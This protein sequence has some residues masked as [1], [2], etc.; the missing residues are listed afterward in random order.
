MKGSVGIRASQELEFF[1]PS[2]IFEESGV[3]NRI[4]MGMPGG[5]IGGF[6]EMGVMVGGV[7]GVGKIEVFGLVEGLVNG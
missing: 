2:V 1:L 4:D 6:L 3:G 7:C 5:S